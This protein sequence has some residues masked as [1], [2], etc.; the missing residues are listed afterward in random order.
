MSAELVVTV[1]GIVIASVLTVYVYRRTNPKR[2]VR[3]RMEV[4]SLL[5]HNSLA[6]GRLVVSLGAHAV[7]SPHIVTITVWSSGRAD[8]PSQAFD[9]GKPMIFDLGAPILEGVP[10]DVPQEP[11]ILIEQP[12]RLAL[13]PALLR[14]GFESRIQVV[15]DGTPNLQVTHSLIDIPVVPDV[16]GETGHVIQASRKRFQPT[17]LS[18]GLTALVLAFVL[19]TIGLIISASDRAAGLAWGTPAILLGILAIPTVLVGGII[20][21]VKW[22]LGR[23][24]PSR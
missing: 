13:R 10:E 23:R 4:T 17:T 19:L 14:K 8:I 6:G 3:Y 12:S 22:R 20:R 11:Q 9:G 1:L 18:V 15:V 2:I 21:V 7:A 5:S 16:V 24:S